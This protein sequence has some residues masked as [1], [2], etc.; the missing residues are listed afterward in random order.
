MCGLQLTFYTTNT[1]QW[2]NNSTYGTC[3]R[4]NYCILMCGC[5]NHFLYIFIHV[6]K[7][8][9]ARLFKYVNVYTNW[10]LMVY[11]IAESISKFGSGLFLLVQV[12]LLL[13]FVH[14]W[15]ESWVSKDEQ[16]WFVNLSFLVLVLSPRILFR[17]F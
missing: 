11:C 2:H 12:I 5:M 7:N 14:A 13:D 3:I 10:V 9:I 16:F 6:T 1:C 17:C 15:N 8:Q 4:L